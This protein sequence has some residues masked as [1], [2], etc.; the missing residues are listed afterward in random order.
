[1]VAEW[2]IKQ[3]RNQNETPNC[4]FN[5]SSSFSFEQWLALPS[6]N[7]L[8]HETTRVPEINI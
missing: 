8:L 7:F 6:G 4:A 1:L 3:S 2:T 5:F